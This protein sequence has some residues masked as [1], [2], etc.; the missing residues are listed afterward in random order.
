MAVPVCTATI[1]GVHSATYSYTS[2]NSLVTLTGVATNS[3][4]LEWEWSV[5]PDNS[6]NR[7]GYPAG[8]VVATGTVNDFLDGISS[9]QNPSVTLDKVGGYCFS[10]RARNADG[11]SDPLSDDTSCQAIPYILSQNGLRF[12]PENEFGYAQDLNLTLSGLQNLNVDAPPLSP[13]RW[14][15]EFDDGVI[16]PKWTWNR[17]GAPAATDGAYVESYGETF[18]KLW[19]VC[20]KDA[21]NIGSTH[22]IGQTAPTVDFTVTAKFNLLPILNFNNV[23]LWFDNGADGDNKLLF[24]RCGNVAVRGLTAYYMNGGAATESLSTTFYGHTFY[25]RASYVAS[26]RV[27]TL[28]FSFDGICWIYRGTVTAAWD[29]S[30]FGVYWL[31]YTTTSHSWGASVE[32]FRVTTP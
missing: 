5:D 4:I 1:S 3:P 21:V 16:D 2:V 29:I 10:L 27:Y 23:G 26:T 28:S 31:S 13:S 18:G 15:D 22:A 19:A 32:H 17:A 25:L 9:S 8:S 30:R 7:G 6:L 12:P 14:D 11:W 20:I 24:W